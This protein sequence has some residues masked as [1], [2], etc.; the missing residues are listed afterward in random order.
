VTDRGGRAKLEG[1]I[2]EIKIALRVP[3]D[4]PTPNFARAGT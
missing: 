2:S 1:G 3:P 4:Y